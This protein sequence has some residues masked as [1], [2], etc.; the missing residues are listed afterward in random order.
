MLESGLLLKSKLKLLPEKIGVYF[1]LDKGDNILYVGKSKNI[2]KRVRYY[3]NKKT[4]KNNLIINNAFYVDY[5]LVDSEEDALFLEN[6]LIKK[7]QPKYNVLLKDD[8]NFPWLCIKKERF[9]RVVV[10]RKKTNNSD[11]YFGPYVSRKL[12]NNLFKLISDMYPVRSCNFNLSKDNILKKKYKVCLDYHLNK[13][14]GPCEGL[15]TEEDYN[16]NINYIKNILSGRFSFVLKSLE[17]LLKKYSE[18]LLFEKAEIIKNQI[19]SIKKI[20]KRSS[21]VYKKNIDIDSFY[22]HSVG[23]FSYV[24]FIRVVEG[25]VVYLKTEKIK[26][27]IFD[28]VFVLESFI[29]RIF[30]NYGFLSKIIISNIDIGFFINKKIFVPKNGYKKDLL[31]LGYTNILEYIKNDSSVNT[32]ILKNLKKVLILK[33]IPLK[34]ECFDIST[35]NGENTVGSC[36]VFNNG[37]IS[38]KNYKYYLLNDIGN[39]DYLSIEKTIEKRYYNKLNIPDLIIIDGG[40]GQLS[41][42]LKVLKKLNINNV[43]IISIA[44]KEEII[45]LKNFK[46]I[47]LNKKSN[48]LKLIQNIRNEAH[49]YCLKNHRILRNNKFISSELNNIRGV[50]K[51][52]IIKLYNNFKSIEKIKNSTKKELID[53]LGNYKSNLVYKHFNK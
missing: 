19:N 25:S 27:N 7:H 18:K 35:L 1:F 24:N 32:S 6:N 3:F 52:S 44:K 39:N 15:Q 46:K 38:K 26:N 8:K 50:G 28:D 37:I 14:L 11:L 42:A 5:I 20:K 2:K 31:N 22:I 45:F 53:I 48:S 40:K 9:P 36:V 17:L 10:V 29:K 33:K 4:K 51:S 34:I 23:S 21:V 41:S 30:I 12:L 13:C 49:N 43:D 16:N 47:I